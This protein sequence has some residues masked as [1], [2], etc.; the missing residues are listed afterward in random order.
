MPDLMLI[1]AAGSKGLL[2]CDMADLR[3]APPTTHQSQNA[4]NRYWAPTSRQYSTPR[5]LR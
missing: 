3:T 1:F 2:L 5:S 4:L